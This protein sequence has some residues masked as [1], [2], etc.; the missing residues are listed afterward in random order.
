MEKEDDKRNIIDYVFCWLPVVL[1]L[2]FSPLF[3]ANVIP[4]DYMVVTENATFDPGT[5]L[6][7][8]CVSIGADGITLD[9]NGAE[10]IGSFNE[11][12][13][14]TY[15]VTC[16]GR[17]SVTIRNGVI[18]GYYYGM[19]I[20]SGS[21]IEIWACDLS[22]NW[23]DPDSLAAPAPWLNINVNPNLNDT[24]NLGGGLFMKGVAEA[25]VSGNT[26]NNEENG[27]DLFNVTGSLIDHNTAFQGILSLHQ[28]NHRSI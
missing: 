7:P 16:I 1:M 4:T 9:M 25:V 8:N 23:V 15:G 28:D 2:G 10:L 22:G 19:R 21:F 26:M 18:N 14:G 3:A 12:G 17:D 20:E 5:C 27:I 13:P 24:V 6:L 11:T